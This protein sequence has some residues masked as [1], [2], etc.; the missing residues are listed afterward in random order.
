MEEVLVVRLVEARDLMPGVTS[1]LVDSFMKLT[2]GSATL[3]SKTARGLPVFVTFY[4]TLQCIQIA[5][6]KNLEPDL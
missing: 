2:F 6:E 1:G 3:K 5:G 4:L